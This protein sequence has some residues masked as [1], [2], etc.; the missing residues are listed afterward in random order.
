MVV[1]GG[2]SFSSL[3]MLEDPEFTIK[4][5]AVTDPYPGASAAEVKRR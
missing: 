3:A 1:V 2:I 4:E 5:A